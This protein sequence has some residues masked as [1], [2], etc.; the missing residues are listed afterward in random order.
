MAQFDFELWK[1]QTAANLKTRWQNFADN[2]LLFAIYG[3][4]AEPASRCYKRR[5]A[6]C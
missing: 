6:E 2:T 3:R 1:N 5:Q 4:R